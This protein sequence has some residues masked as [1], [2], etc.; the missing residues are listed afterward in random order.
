[1]GDFSA[2]ALAWAWSAVSSFRFLRF[3][4][5]AQ[6][7]EKF[8]HRQRFGGVEF[9]VTHDVSPFFFRPD[10]ACDA[11]ARAGIRRL[12]RGSCAGQC[13]R[14]ACI[15]W[16]SVQPQPS[17]ACAEDSRCGARDGDNGLSSHLPIPKPYG[18]LLTISCLRNASRSAHDKPRA[19]QS[20]KALAYSIHGLRKCARKFRRCHWRKPERVDDSLPK[21]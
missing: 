17:I 1:M 12:L 9:N 21:R 2:A 4:E 15:R 18:R 5:V 11:I 16:V 6:R 3:R 19:F 14:R 7:A 13:S 8:P 20:P 10:I